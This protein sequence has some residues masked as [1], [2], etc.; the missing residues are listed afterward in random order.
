M[1]T[2]WME[3]GRDPLGLTLIFFFL[4]SKDP[5]VSTTTMGV[6]LVKGVYN[7]WFWCRVS[8]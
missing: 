4:E 1:V 7:E 5:A 3:R 2:T 8:S 6:Y